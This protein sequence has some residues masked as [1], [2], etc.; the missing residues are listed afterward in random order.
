MSKPGTSRTGQSRQPPRQLMINPKAPHLPMKQIDDDSIIKLFAAVQEGNIDKIRNVVAEENLILDV[1][2]EV[3]DTVIHKVIDNPNEDFTEDDRLELVRYFIQN[4]VSISTFNKL[5]ITALHLAAKHQ[6]A[7]IVELLLRYNAKVDVY[8]NKNMTPLHYVTQG[9][10]VECK[11]RKKVRSLIPKSSM[12]FQSTG[13][14]LKDLSV[15]I[16]DIFQTEQ[17]KKFLKHIKNSIN[18]IRDIYPDDFRQYETTLLR[19]INNIITNQEKRQDEK[20]ALITSKKLNKLA[21]INAAVENKLKKTLEKMNIYPDQD[22]GWGPDGDPKHRV[23]PHENTKA[24]IDK[25]DADY[26]RDKTTVFTNLDTK[27]QNISDQTS[28]LEADA[29]KLF[30]DMHGIVMH[31]LNVR[32]NRVFLSDGQYYVSVINSIVTRMLCAIL[33][34]IIIA[35]SSGLAATTAINIA[36]LRGV[37]DSNIV[38]RTNQ[39]IT[40][41]HSISIASISKIFNYV[42]GLAGWVPNAYNDAQLIPII[43]QSIH[44]AEMVVGGLSTPRYNIA[45]SIVLANWAKLIIDA[46][47]NDIVTTSRLANPDDIGTITR[48]KNEADDLWTN[49]IPDSITAVNGIPSTSKND[50]IPS[51]TI[52]LNALN[53]G[54]KLAEI[55]ALKEEKRGNPQNQIDQAKKVASIVRKIVNTSTSVNKEVSDIG[56]IAVTNDDL[57]NY[58]S[59]DVV[60]QLDSQELDS[61][62]K[63]PYNEVDFNITINSTPEVQRLKKENID[64]RRRNRIP[65]FKLTNDTKFNINVTQRALVGE[66]LTGLLPT[67]TAAPNISTL[68]LQ[69]GLAQT[70]VNYNPVDAA[71]PAD[72]GGKKYFFMSR[73]YYAT[74]RIRWHFDIIEKSIAVIKD[75]FNKDFYFEIYHHVITQIVTSMINISQYLAFIYADKNIMIK[76]ATDIRTEFTNRFNQF[77][78]HPYSFS[79]EYAADLAQDMITTTNKIS[80]TLGNFY[81]TITEIQNDLNTVIELTNKA[82]SIKYI[83]SY[84]LDGTNDRLFQNGDMTDMNNIYDRLLLLLNKLPEQFEKYTNM[85]ISES[86]LNKLRKTLYEKYIPNINIYNYA[87]YYTNGIPPG[88]VEYIKHDGTTTAIVPPGASRKSKIGYL[89]DINLNGVDQ[90]NPSLPYSGNAHGIHGMDN[91]DATLQ[92]LIGYHNGVYT[93]QVNPPSATKQREVSTIASINGSLDQHLYTLKYELI[94]KI[95]EIFN[96]APPAPPAHILDLDVI[97]AAAEKTIKSI[98]TNKNKIKAMLE[99]DKDVSLFT[100][101]GSIADQIIVKYIKDMIKGSCAKIINNI[102][103]RPT[104]DDYDTTLNK[105]TSKD[106]PLVV[107]KDPGFE[108]NFNKLIKDLT[109]QFMEKTPTDKLEYDKLKLTFPTMADEDKISDQY[110]IYNQDYRSTGE[111]T[112]EQCY[113][114]NPKIVD[115][116]VKKYKLLVNKKD[117]N[118]STPIF[119]AISTMHA[120]LVKAL[121]DNGAT[122]YY[123][124]IKN[125]R[126]LT[127]VDHGFDLYKLHY[128]T[129]NPTN[130]SIPDIMKQFYQSI[131]MDIRKTIE[132]KPQYKN[133]IIVY[134]DLIFPELILMYNHLLYLYMMKYIRSWSY[135]DYKKLCDIL[136]NYNVISASSVTSRD[137][138]L[139]NVTTDDM[140]KHGVTTQV[141]TKQISDVDDELVQKKQ[142]KVDE[143]VNKITS[144]DK[145]IKDLTPY[146]SDPVVSK[147]I[148]QKNTLK[149]DLATEKTTLENAINKTKT[150]DELHFLTDNLTDLSTEMKTIFNTELTTFKGSA[151]FE[152]LLKVTKNVTDI[153]NKIISSDFLK[154]IPQTGASNKTT[155]NYAFYNEMWNSYANDSSKLSNLTNIH[156]LCMTLQNEF[157]N[158]FDKT[159]VQSLDGDM[160]IL[161]KL[162]DNIFIYLINNYRELPKEYNDADNDMMK[163]II[164]II[165]HVL[166]NIV[167]SNLYYSIL[168]TLTAYLIS[169]DP[170]NE[171]RH[172]NNK[173]YGRIISQSVMNIVEPNDASGNPTKEFQ[174]YIVDTIPL[175][176]VK[177]ILKIYDGDFDDDKEIKSIKELMSKIIDMFKATTVVPITDDTSFVNNL[178]TY[179][180]P[181]YEDLFQQIVPAMKAVIENYNRYILN[182]A[183]YIQIMSLL[184]NKAAKEVK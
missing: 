144:I 86:D 53:I 114:I 5:N 42:N 134:F 127:P 32:T 62:T 31:N 96:A 58:F 34:P 120:E 160:A 101:V 61:I 157:I 156:L 36:A 66:D 133:N 64:E 135:D 149:T 140:F 71:K 122:V 17:F 172:T 39:D 1:T 181:Y 115:L 123:P 69:P 177:H 102:G 10:V 95:I 77:K 83:K 46:E 143:L 162:Y 88:I 87:T 163:Q 49:I 90:P 113:K 22:K 80:E 40:D 173:K 74:K 51:L 164:D 128:T 9:N 184:L 73:V 37:L 119:Y 44:D 56:N 167:C 176:I 155:T 138:P 82:S 153:Y 154:K 11:K 126:G 145:E 76:K 179:I 99:G 108:A 65:R 170:Y 14:K 159:S 63:I 136:I 26:T 98:I 94:K 25:I 30:E 4:G 85:Y 111:I 68:T 72:Y 107:T 117:N 54:L 131:K 166:S 2:D 6:Y 89:T 52:T 79:L 130:A 150:T 45:V 146:N 121:I 105:I 59:Y 50:A 182:E 103:S 35:K 124:N 141:L 169:V 116:L 109:K 8:D 118:Q 16:V 171:D 142:A 148:A 147:Y 81:R 21:E 180:F 57:Q 75:H 13:L 100:I 60:S 137:I 106:I 29:R 151:D 165:T 175:K 125:S 27:V 129:V 7:K 28:S 15:T 55:L 132:M 24:I 23:L 19:D 3:G 112:E 18:D 158:R 67:G 84:H 38:P 33:K 97:P 12:K 104:G 70:L 152:N 41:L 110:P 161:N 43:N 47:E 93:V 78:S 20:D 139:L 91:G 168:K 174:T 92:G 48:L 183:R 178:N